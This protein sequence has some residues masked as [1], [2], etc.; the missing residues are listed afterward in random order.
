MK[1]IALVC[2]GLG[3]LGSGCEEQL[4]GEAQKVV[5]QIKA[6]AS[7]AATKAIDDLKTDALVKLKSVQGEP[8]R[9][10]QPQ[11]KT[12]KTEDVVVQK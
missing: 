11:E 7:K 10:D 8:E 5:E 12:G 6:E 4:T 1:H 3:L 9:K 2:L